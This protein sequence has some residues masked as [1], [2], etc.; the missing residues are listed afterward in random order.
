MKSVNPLESTKVDPFFGPVVETETASIYG[1][2]YDDVVSK[3]RD[4]VVTLVC[5][6]YLS[7]IMDEVVEYQHRLVK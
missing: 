2:V 6:R 4:P 1:H 5:H 3:V 7:P